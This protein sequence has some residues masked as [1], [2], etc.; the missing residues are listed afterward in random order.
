M[1]ERRRK[2]GDR[3]DILTEIAVGGHRCDDSVALF[4]LPF[5]SLVILL[6]D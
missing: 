6:L 3:N 5:Y 4:S 2:R 1:S